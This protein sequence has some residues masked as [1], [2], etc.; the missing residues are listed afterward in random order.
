[1]PHLE[2]L[3]EN[4]AMGDLYQPPPHV[5]A[6]AFTTLATGK[7]PGRHRILA[8]WE[9]DPLT[10]FPRAISRASLRAKPIWE[11]LEDAGLRAHVCNWPATHPAPLLRGGAVSN[12]FA[13]AT[14]ALPRDWPLV[15]NAVHPPESETALTGL[16]VHPADI[17]AADLR[18]FVPRLDEID[19]DND[20]RL[21]PLAGAVAE[22][23]TAHAA[24]TWQL[25][26][27]QPAFLA[28]CYPL[29]GAACRHYL[30]YPETD[31]FGGAVAAAC[32]FQD[33]MLG[34]ILE[35]AGADALIV[36]ISAH[37]FLTGVAAP[38]PQPAAGDFWPRAAFSAPA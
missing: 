23:V 25:E 8:N 26:H 18:Y 31:V 2:A 19:Q 11:I 17:A 28:V 33:R 5:P 29:I 27:S 13:P 9:P 14:T 7:P 20:K 21:I 32:Q 10:A 3:V 12:L 4:G 36:I 35:L 34:T 16:R 37:G 15:A 1:M 22:S 6:L 30:R 24:A 38:G